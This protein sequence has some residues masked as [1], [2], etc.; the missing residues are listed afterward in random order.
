MGVKGLQTY[1]ENYC[2]DAC[3]EVS[4]RDLI[5]T[6]RRETGRV[7]VIVVDGSSCLRYLYGSLDWVLGGQFKEYTEKLLKFVTAFESLGA[8]L[9]FYFDGATIERK[10]P[11]WIQRRLKSLQ[12]V[13][14]IFDCLNKWKRLSY[15]DQSLFQL[16][17]GLGGITRF[18][19]KDVCGCEVFTSIRECDE[20]IAEYAHSRHC[21]AILG[22][23]T[24]YIIFD[25]AQ[26]YLSMMNLNLLAMTTLNYNRWALARHL[27]IHP[28]QLPILASLIGNDVVP[29]DDLKAFHIDICSHPDGRK[30]NSNSRIR[31]D[32]LMSHV[33]GFIRTLP[34]GEDVFQVLPAIAH[35]VFRD[36]RRASQLNASIRS[37]FIDEPSTQSVKEE[38]TSEW[39]KI[40]SLARRRHTRCENPAPVWAVMNGLPY[41]SSTA[42][43][44]FR[45]MDLPPAA[46]ALRPLRQRIYGLLLHEKPK[47]SSE[48]VT[49]QEWCMYGED[50]LIQPALVEPVNIKGRE[51]TVSF[52]DLSLIC[53]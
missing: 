53:I 40:M 15:V 52:I 29:A 36:E 45:E 4:I 12:D 35:K 31:Y 28:N 41:E 24:D 16:P 20:E 8:K 32:I 11:V 48:P 47:T 37:Y 22:Q 7:P 19:F 5:E 23:D 44:D 6:Y 51:S 49:V 33:A 21:F 38:P 30:Y 10:R 14:K 13:Y 26:Y 50:S 42:L 2:P 39:S 27:R 18:L 1:I 43:E 25:G 9:V 17:A 46:L 3:Y 34:C